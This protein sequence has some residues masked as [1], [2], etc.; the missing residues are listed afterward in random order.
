[1]SSMYD[2]IRRDMEYAR[3]ARKRILE[4]CS[5]VDDQKARLSVMERVAN[6]ADRFL[7]E[8]SAAFMVSGQAVTE[9]W[10][11]NKVWRMRE[12]RREV[13]SREA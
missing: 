11:M 9:S 10:I 8:L 12:M 1:M 13:V 3:F 6:D 7:L 5:E 2:E 4:L